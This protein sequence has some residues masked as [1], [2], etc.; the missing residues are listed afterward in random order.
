MNCF[1][2]GLPL[3][4]NAKFCKQCGASQKPSAP[5]EPSLAPSSAPGRICSQCRHRCNPQAK[6]CPQCGLNF[7]SPPEIDDDLH[8]PISRMDS[9][10]L[11]DP[12]P[13]RKSV[14]STWIIGILVVAVIGLLAW[15][16]LK[17]NTA[18][19]GETPSSTAPAASPDNGKNPTS[20]PNGE[21]DDRA[22]AESLVGP[23]GGT[24]AP[25]PSGQVAPVTTQ[26]VPAASSP[27]VASPAT[28]PVIDT[29]T[30][31]APQPPA[32][33][34]SL[35]SQGTATPSPRPAPEV[36]PAPAPRPDPNRPKTL[37]DLLM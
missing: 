28:P 8:A 11:P 27:S 21:I 31:P 10:P 25:L 24:P 26:P 13:A 6:F 3:A 16:F 18:L 15:I 34:P 37:D 33:T 35:P 19:L 2:C 32:A 22:R 7:V 5:K 23:M 12:V 1:E 29:N 14:S 20:L 4:P 9:H 17:P 30:A 36:A